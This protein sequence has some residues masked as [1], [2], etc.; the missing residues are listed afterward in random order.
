MRA[1]HPDV[2]VVGAGIAGASVAAVLARGGLEVLLL[3]RQWST[4]IGSVAS[5]WPPGACWRRAPW[6]SKVR[7]ARRR[8]LT[9][10]TRCHST[11]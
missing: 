2:V 3:E 10:A 1:S 5:T 7:S 11:N 4:A 9:D 8:R 6:G